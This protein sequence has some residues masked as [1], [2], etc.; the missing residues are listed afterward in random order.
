MQLCQEKNYTADKLN[1]DHFI[2]ISVNQR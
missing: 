2:T 1:E